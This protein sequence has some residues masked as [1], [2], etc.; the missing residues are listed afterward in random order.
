[1]FLDIVKAF[2]RVPRELLWDVL[3]K[4]GVN[5]KLMRLLNK[6]IRL[7]LGILVSKFHQYLVRQIR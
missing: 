1:M 6:T 2:D 4:F 3:G 5:G 7:S